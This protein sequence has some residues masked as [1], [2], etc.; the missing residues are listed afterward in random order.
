MDN[1]VWTE[2]PAQKHQRLADEAAG[3]K[4]NKAP[5]KG[6]RDETYE[7]KGKRQRE[8]E[9]RAEVERHNVRVTPSSCPHPTCSW[10]VDRSHRGRNR[11][12]ANRFWTSTKRRD[13]HQRTT[14]ESGIT[15]GTWVS[16]VV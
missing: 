7:S 9:I 5:V 12:E 3:I 14:V 8:E 11:P 1:T 16:L 6:E 13:R 2:T 4:R 15:S 10:P